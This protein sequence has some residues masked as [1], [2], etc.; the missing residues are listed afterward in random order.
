V[1]WSNTIWKGVR[2]FGRY[3]TQD[4]QYSLPG[5]NGKPDNHVVHLDELDGEFRA[6]PE[7]DESFPVL[8]HEMQAIWMKLMESQDEFVQEV[9][10]H[11]KNIALGKAM[12]GLPDVYV[13]R[14]DDRV[15]QELEIQ[16]LLQQQPMIDALP[17]GSFKTIP[18]MLI[19][20]FEDDHNE[21]VEAVKE[22]AVSPAGL[23]AKASN[24]QGYANVIAHGK[25]HED[26]LKLQAM[27]DA[28]MMAAAGTP[29]AATGKEEKPKAGKKS[30]KPPVEKTKEVSGKIKEEL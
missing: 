3:R 24:P 7:T 18:S 13:P 23:K 22:W 21:H 1:F 12:F 16:T 14:Q 27:Q 26:F 10:G 6:F 20:E 17:D 2:E 19:G 8:F 28:Q 25:M 15:K 5:L 9:M 4:E 11:S 29:P 30:N